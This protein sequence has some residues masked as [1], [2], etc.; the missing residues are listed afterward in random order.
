MVAKINEYASL[1]LTPGVR[2]Q[3][4]RIAKAERRTLSQV[5]RFLVE[6]ALEVRNR[7]NSLAAEQSLEQL[8]VKK[9]PLS[10]NQ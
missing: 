4:V 3:V 1:R 10:L 2:Q 8:T 9:D 6:E 5:L 7:R